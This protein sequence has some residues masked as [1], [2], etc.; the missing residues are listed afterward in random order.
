MSYQHPFIITTHVLALRNKK[1][2][3]KS[4]Q[5]LEIKKKKKN[6]YIFPTHEQAC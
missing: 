4:Y 5:P 2:R 6:I 3:K 1:R